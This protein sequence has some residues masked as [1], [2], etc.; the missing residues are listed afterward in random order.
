MCHLWEQESFLFNNKDIKILTFSKIPIPGVLKTVIKI[1][2][3]ST[4]FIFDSYS[5]KEFWNG[6]KIK[7]MLVNK[8]ATLINFGTNYQST[9]LIIFTIIL[10]FVLVKICNKMV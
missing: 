4:R 3:Y 6:L 1:E 7:K 2:I 9:A 10:F 8:F 5:P